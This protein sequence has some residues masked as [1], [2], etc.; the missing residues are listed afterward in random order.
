MG[1]E[2]VLGSIVRGKRRGKLYEGR[3]ND[4]TERNRLETGGCGE[5]RLT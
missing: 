4:F 1:G 3:N 2:T 5:V